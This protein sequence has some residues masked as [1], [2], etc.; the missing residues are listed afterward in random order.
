WWPKQMPTTGLPLVS[1]K[2]LTKPTRA[3]IQA[4]SANAVC[5]ANVHV[6]WVNV[7]WVKEGK[8]V[9]SVNRDAMDQCNVLLPVKRMPST[10]SALGYSCDL[11][12]SHLLSANSAPLYLSPSTPARPLVR[13]WRNTSP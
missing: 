12:T 13:S 5:S 9:V 6:R 10:S 1:R 8:K 4:S 3:T 11:T 7:T 2:D